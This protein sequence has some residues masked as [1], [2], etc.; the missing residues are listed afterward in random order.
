MPKPKTAAERIIDALMGRQPV[1]ALRKSQCRICP[2]WI[3]ARDMTAHLAQ[4]EAEM[5]VLVALTDE[6]ID[7]MY[8]IAQSE[9]E[10]YR[11]AH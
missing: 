8:E 3:T 1:N 10:A 5:P 11:N 4:H 6:D 7:G 9:S 2:E